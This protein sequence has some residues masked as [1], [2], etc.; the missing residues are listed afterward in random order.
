MSVGITTPVTDRDPMRAALDDPAVVE[1]LRNAARAFLGPRGYAQEAADVVQLAGVRA[2]QRRGDFQPDKDPVCWL[3]GFVINTA[4]EHVK[5]A[6][7]AVARPLSAAPELADLA[8]DLGRPVGDALAD[9][10]EVTRLLDRLAPAD[11]ELVRLVYFEGLTFAE[12]GAR[13]GTT[14]TAARVRQHRLLKQL[15]EL[16]G[17]GGVRS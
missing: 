15:R 10:D 11:R 1:R 12:V 13:V 7:R 14:E 5:K 8:A 6:A 2:W 16:A 9:R 4:R 3:V 17:G